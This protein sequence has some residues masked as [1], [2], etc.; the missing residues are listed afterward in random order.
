MNRTF[1]ILSRTETAVTA[2]FASVLSVVTV[3]AVAA[4][5]ATATP[6]DVPKTSVAHVT[7]EKVT[8]TG[9]KSI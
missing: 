2:A 4:L 7:F 8:I 6:P 9:S 3:G 5:F 1:N